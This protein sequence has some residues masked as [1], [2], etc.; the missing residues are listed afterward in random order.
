MTRTWGI[1][2]LGVD[3]GKREAL[4]VRKARESFVA[5]LAEPV[6]PLRFAAQIQLPESAGFDR[7]EDS[8]RIRDAAE[9]R[10]EEHGHPEK[11]TKRAHVAAEAGPG[12]ALDDL[13]R[14]FRAPSQRAPM[15]LAHRGGRDRAAVPGNQ[16]R[17][18]G[19][20]GRTD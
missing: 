3:P 1:G 17:E 11:A 6:T 5:K 12:V 15:D 13:D 7:L 14:D 2:E 4:E 16:L 9:F 10:M 19:P 8:E 20:G 18:Q